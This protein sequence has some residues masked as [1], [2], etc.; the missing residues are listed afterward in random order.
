M[1]F[2]R[3]FTKRIARVVTAKRHHSSRIQHLP[4]GAAYACIFKPDSRWLAVRFSQLYAHVAV[5][6]E[7]DVAAACV[8]ITLCVGGAL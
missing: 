6:T 4:L 7:T 3:A 2:L 8:H 1:V 5:G